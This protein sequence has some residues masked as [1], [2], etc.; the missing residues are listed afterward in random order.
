MALVR[1]PDDGLE[2]GK[3]GFFHWVAGYKFTAIFSADVALLKH[4][5]EL[6]CF[7]LCRLATLVDVLS[8]IL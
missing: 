3:N 4:S 1:G 7:L 2:R 6:L 5:V 8:Q